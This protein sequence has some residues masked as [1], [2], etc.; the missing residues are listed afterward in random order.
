[1]ENALPHAF[2]A[3][4][5]TALDVM[6]FYRFGEEKTAVFN[7][8]YLNYIMGKHTKRDSI[9]LAMG[10]LSIFENHGFT[11]SEQAGKK[12]TDGEAESFIYVCRMMCRACPDSDI[13]KSILL[14]QPLF[15]NEKEKFGDTFIY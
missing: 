2:N 3:T 13:T 14:L 10:L 8:T 4:A 6:L 12:L 9:N 1:M 11:H 7:P 5:L 15:I